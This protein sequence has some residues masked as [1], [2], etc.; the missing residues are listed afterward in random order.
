MI[1]AASPSKDVHGRTRQSVLPLTT[2]REA[3]EQTR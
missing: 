2:F 3:A 1:G